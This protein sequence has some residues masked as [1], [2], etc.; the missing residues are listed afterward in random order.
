[1]LSG[2][3]KMKNLKKILF[4]VSNSFLHAVY[5]ESLLWSSNK[6]NEVQ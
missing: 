6:Y 2:K 1:M 3:L 4:E 5:L